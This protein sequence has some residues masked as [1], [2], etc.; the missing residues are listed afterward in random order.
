MGREGPEIS[1]SA[2]ACSMSRVP[3]WSTACS[4]FLGSRLRQAGGQA[5]RHLG[6]QDMAV[7]EPRRCGASMC[8]ARKC[9]RCKHMVSPIARLCCIM[10]SSQYLSVWRDAAL[11]LGGPLLGVGLVCW[12]L[13]ASLWGAALLLVVLSSLLVHLMG[14]MLIAG[15]CAGGGSTPAAAG[16]GSVFAHHPQL[17]PAGRGCMWSEEECMSTRG[18]D[19]T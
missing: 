7:Q 8:V 10:V 11:L 3:P 1:C 9:L 15:G 12:V 2:C 19:T 17:P 14:A 6:R 4:V 5:G 13:T 18:F 16:G